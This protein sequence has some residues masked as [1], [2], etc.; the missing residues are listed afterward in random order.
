[1]SSVFQHRRAGFT[2]VEIMIVVAIIALLAA[3]AV[4]NFIR[5]RKRAQ[6]ASILE[7]FRIIDHAID[8][9]AIESNRAGSGAG[10]GWAWP[11]IL[12]YMKR[13]TRLYNVMENSRP[14]DIL[15]GEYKN[16]PTVEVPPEATTPRLYVDP[17]TVSKLSDAV[18]ADFW[19][20]YN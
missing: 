17:A 8:Q 7:D 1:M 5:A 15:G 19:S 9:Y 20:P 18:S 4:P 11:D 2:L 3:I 12:K 6:A 13:G 10:G 16:I 14:L